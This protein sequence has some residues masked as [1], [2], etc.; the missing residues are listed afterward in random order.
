MNNSQ[1]PNS[2]IALIF[3]VM[4]MT[5]GWIFFHL[6]GNVERTKNRRMLQNFVF[7]LYEFQRWITSVVKGIDTG[8]SAYYMTMEKSKI[9]PVN[10][11]KFSAIDTTPI[12]TEIQTSQPGSR[13]IETIMFWRLDKKSQDATN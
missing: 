11:R 3:I 6:F 13:F 12:R 8:I 10:E 5:L 7:R 4:F 2:T 9:S 1:I